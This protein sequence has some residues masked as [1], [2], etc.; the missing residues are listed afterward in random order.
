[1]PT[2]QPRRFPMPYHANMALLVL[3]EHH[4]SCSI[5]CGGHQHQSIFHPTQDSLF[6]QHP[7]VARFVGADGVKLPFF[8]GP[9]SF[10]GFESAI[11]IPCDFA[12]LLPDPK[13]SRRILIQA[14]NPATL[15]RRGGRTIYDRKPHTIKSDQPAIS[16]Q[17]QIT[18]PSLDDGR[19]RV[20][21][22]TVL[23]L[24]GVRKI[25]W[26]SRRGERYQA[27][28]NPVEGRPSE[29][30]SREVGGAARHY[31]RILI[32]GLQRQ[33]APCSPNGPAERGHSCPQQCPECTRGHWHL[34]L[35]KIAAD[36][37]VDRNVRAPGV[38]ARS[39]CL[40]PSFPRT[41]RTS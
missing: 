13:G 7:N 14:R 18:V 12:S 2:N 37:N 29:A 3:R 25:V 23:S 5:A 6:V 28:Q 20:L 16:P 38:K 33:E 34:P 35:S 24:P 39:P 10:N 11:L 15:Q 21:R 36:R 17:P 32:V 22:Q 4:L 40:G 30:S 41:G 1:M 27:K 9:G 19:D 26:S 8:S 31:P